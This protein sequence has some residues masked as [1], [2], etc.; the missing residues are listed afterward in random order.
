V[1]VKIPIVLKSTVPIIVIVAN[2]PL[3]RVPR[4]QGRVVHPPCDELTLESTNPLGKISDTATL[5]ASSEPVF[6]TVKV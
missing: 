4:L 6:I 2:V 3:V 5:V 1:L